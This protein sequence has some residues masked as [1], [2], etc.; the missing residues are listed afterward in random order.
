MVAVDRIIA[1]RHG[2]VAQR[3]DCEP[4]AGGIFISDTD[5]F[6]REIT[7]VLNSNISPYYKKVKQLTR[8]FPVYF[9]EIGA[10]G[11]IRKVTTTMD[12]I[13]G[14]QDKLVHFLR[15]QVHTESNNTLIGLTLKIF[16]FWHDGDLDKLRPVLPVNVYS[17]IDKQSEWFAPVHQMV[18]E[19]C[20]I[21]QSDPEALLMLSQPA[22]D[23]L[24]QQ[25]ETKNQRDMERLHDIHSLYAHLREKYSFESVNI[26]Q[27]L[28][29]YPFIAEAEIEKLDKAL[30]T[31]DFK[32]S[33]RLI[34]GFMDKLRKIIFNPEESEGWENIYHK[35]HIAIGIPS[36]YGV[37]R[38]NKF[39]ALGLTF[40]L[41]KVATRLMEKVVGNI[42]LDY[43]SATTL[44]EIHVILDY[45]R[46][47]LELDGITNQ[48][49]NSNLQM[50][51]YSLT[52]RSFSFDQYINIF[53]FIAQDIR[54]IIIKYFL[55]SYE[56]PLK[57]VV[58]Q[59]FDPTQKLS[60]K[61]LNQ[62]LVK[63]SE[64]FHRDVIAEAFLVQ[65][66]DNFISRILFSLGNMSDK[67][68]K[69]LINDI[70][71]YNN[72]LVISPLEERTPKMDNQVFLGSKAY[73]L[74]TSISKVFLY[75]Q[76]L[77]SL[78]RFSGE[79][80]PSWHCPN[81][82]RSFTNCSGAT[83]AEWSGFREKN[84]EMLQ[85]RSCFRFA[86]EQPYPCLVPWIPS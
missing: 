20:R 37:Y 13:S 29:R 64:E 50:L 66:L 81:C 62:L 14:R 19:M 55:K 71:T 27:L 24:L 60:E 75:H 2:K 61:E 12:E 53:Q 57:V 38:E 72:E 73:H 34:Y 6:Q 11:E 1:F 84:L 65:P 67:L 28:Q 30:K 51:R 43:I 85:T 9:N 25:L 8:I 49:F 7:K 41:E 82:G 70:M 74:K 48:S 40:R 45:F 26:I 22:F 10:E 78:R 52:S 23:Q 69:S 59:L 33:L 18:N 35:R 83:S 39:E 15:K 36:M 47:G 4:A 31:N 16:R 5:L 63:K 3:L 68:D 80:A 17:A 56:Y 79:T 76:V 21:N 86:Q 44:E 58:P 32:R 54:R 77:S 46:E 42:N